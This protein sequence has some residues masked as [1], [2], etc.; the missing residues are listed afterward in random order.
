MHNSSSHKRQSLVARANFLST[1]R[2]DIQFAV[3]QL[4]VNMLKPNNQD[5]ARLK[6]LARYLQGRMRMVIKYRWQED[7]AEVSAY[8][9]SDWASA[10][11]RK[12]VNE[13][14]DDK[15][16]ITHHQDVELNTKRDSPLIRR[17]RVLRSSE[18]SFT[19]TRDE[20]DDG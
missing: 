9:D 3:R 2:P 13:R 5:Y 12:E 18:G 14:R 1:V 20:Q 4:A 7:P 15:I 6:R 19:I 17:G 8:S 11:K 10:K 16:W